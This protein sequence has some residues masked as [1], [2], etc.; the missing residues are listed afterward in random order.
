MFPNLCWR[1][2]E[3]DQRAFAE[4]RRRQAAE[5]A[6]QDRGARE[7]PSPDVELPQEDQEA[8]AAGETAN[9]F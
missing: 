4:I 9:P 7:Q 3:A 2:L 1:L 8:P 6:Q 5:P